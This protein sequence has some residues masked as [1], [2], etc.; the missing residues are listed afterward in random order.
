[1]HHARNMER[2]GRLVFGGNRSVVVRYPRNDYSKGGGVKAKVKCHYASDIDIHRAWFRVQQLL[3]AQRHRASPRYF[4]FLHYNT[5]T[6]W[7]GSIPLGLVCSSLLVVGSP[8]S[9]G[10]QVAFCTRN[11]R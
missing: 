4:V 10:M 3:F 7:S 1:M 11:D 9:V 6:D 2:Q 5:T 8:V